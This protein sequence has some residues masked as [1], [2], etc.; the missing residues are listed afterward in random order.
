MGHIKRA[1]TVADL[2]LDTSAL[3]TTLATDLFVAQEAIRDHQ[4]SQSSYIT[5]LIAP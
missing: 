1:A 5:F 4:Q 2:L 3:G